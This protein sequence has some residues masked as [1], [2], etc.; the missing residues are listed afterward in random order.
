MGQPLM[1]LKKKVWT[2]HLVSLLVYIAL[3]IAYEISYIFWI[4]D[5]QYQG[6]TDR[7]LI[8]LATIELFFNLSSMCL[9]VLLFWMIDQMTRQVDEE[10]FN[11]IL[12]RKVPHYVYLS[13]C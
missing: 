3:W 13:Q 6:I 12:Q 11:P 7:K 5:T 2:A 10:R 8:A 9:E 1:R 4:K